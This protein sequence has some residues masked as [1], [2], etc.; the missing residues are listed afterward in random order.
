MVTTELATIIANDAF[1]KHTPDKLVKICTYK[2]KGRTVSW[3]L[4]EPFGVYWTAAETQAKKRKT[5]NKSE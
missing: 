5:G 4:K 3:L 1:G 2:A